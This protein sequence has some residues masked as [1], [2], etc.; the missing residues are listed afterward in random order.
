MVRQAP[1]GEAAETILRKRYYGPGEDWELL[2]LRVAMDLAEAE[3]TDGEKSQ[4][5]KKFYD[6]MVDGYGLPN[7][8]TL[9]N[10]G[11]PLQQLSACFVLPVP[12]DTTGIFNAVRD[13]ALVHKSGGGTGF[14]F[15]ELRPRGSTVASTGGVASG[16]VGFIRV[17]DTTTD[18]IKQGGTRRGANMATLRVDHPDIMEF[19]TSKRD[20]SLT[21]FNISVAVTDAFMEAVSKDYDWKLEWEL[22]WGGEVVKLVKAREIW[23]AIIEAAHEC[24][25]PGLIFLDRINQ[26]NPNPHLGPITGVNPCGE[27]PLFVNEACNLGS[28]NL[29]KHIVGGTLDWRHLSSTIQTMYRM[30]D[31]V[32]TRTQWPTPE[33]AAQSLA[34]RR[35]GVGVMGWA[36][37]LIKLKIAYDSPNAFDLARAVSKNI[38]DTLKRSNQALS[39]QRGAYPECRIELE[40]LRNSAPYTIA[41]TGTISM[42]AGCSSGI[43]PLYALVTERQMAEGDDISTLH[44]LAAEYYQTYPEL[45]PLAHEISWHKH[46]LAQAAWQKYCPNGVSK[47]INMPETALVE[48]VEKA[49]IM[50]WTQGCKGIT[51]YR[52][53]SK[54]NQVLRAA[55]IPRTQVGLVPLTPEGSLDTLTLGDIDLGE[56]KKL[57]RPMIVEGKTIRMETGHGRLYIVVNS[58]EGEPFEV[59]G[60]LDQDNPCLASTLT[61]I[62]RLASTALRYGIPVEEVIEQLRGHPCC[63][64]WMEGTKIQSVVDAVAQAIIKV[65]DSDL[66]VWYSGSCPDCGK[67]PLRHSEG[68]AHCVHCGY[69]KC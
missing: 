28:V 57:E 22:T 6:M 38:A 63:P 24:G 27:Q 4:W 10:A 36:D 48:D 58:K 11:K 51:I 2:C 39:Y 53:G 18:V 25:D 43:E 29:S 23:N 12:D 14:D 7:S 59:F 9:M 40:S 41:P 42:I 30:L 44:P 50:A 8:P 19:I 13:A 35:V 5:S 60:A 33:I 1:G 46:I 65:G 37:A 67:H 17:F 26:D 34:T 15:S 45:F 56:P 49:Y 68:C 21:N 20:G 62:T 16:P 52:D 55:P 66:S 3:A 32:V 61:G 69:S 54:P 47:T 31:N 64:T